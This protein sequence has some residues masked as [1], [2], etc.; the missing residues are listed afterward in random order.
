MN[1]TL[2][3]YLGKILFKLPRGCEVTFMKL[4]NVVWSTGNGGNGRKYN[5][6]QDS[7]KGQFLLSLIHSFGLWIKGG[8]LP[9]LLE[10]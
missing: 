7:L 6:L 8:I 10:E 1:L 3:N 4:Y 5:D 9:S 2:S